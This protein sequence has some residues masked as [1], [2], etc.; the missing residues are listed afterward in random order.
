MI[1]T[2]AVPAGALLVVCALQVGAGNAFAQAPEEPKRDPIA[3]ET[4]FARGKQLM[5][6]GQVPEACEAFKESQRLDPAGG[7]LLRLAL[8]HEAQGK[9]AS[10]WLEFTEV[11]RVS[12]AAGDQGKQVERVRLA[13]QHLEAIEPRLPK[14]VVS[15]PPASRV[16]GLS[17]T[18]NG[19]PRNPGTWGVAIPVDAGE[20]AIEATAPGR[21]P[22]RT[23]VA[24]VEGKESTLEVPMLDAAPSA[25]PASAPDLAF[26]PA[27]GEGEGR[28][29]GAPLRPIAL[30]AAG[31][32]LVAIGV[33]AYF[34]VTAMSK[35]SD[36]N[37]SCS[38]STCATAAGVSSAHDAKQ[39]AV[40]AD[41]TIG[42]GFA[43][44]AA[45]AVLYFLGAPKTVQA[46]ADGVRVVF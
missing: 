20:V 44:V 13:R 33:G 43:A 19:S 2:S 1:A 21:A 24:A 15:V 7:T 12:Q 37:A 23:T 35:W 22:F 8:C 42:V 46:R 6:R 39:A 41:V 29:G 25:M 30:G 11:V 5:E 32:G 14:L 9:L 16:D 36:S 26:T 27:R 18:A 31:V 3:A 45:G 28:G 4:L 38:G 34:G 40:I 17:V 10:A